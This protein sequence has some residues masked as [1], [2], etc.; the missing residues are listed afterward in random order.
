M[1]KWIKWILYFFSGIIILLFLFILILQTNWAKGFVR[2]KLQTY[3]SQ[4][5]KTEF[6]IGS[7]DYSLPKWI[8]LNGVFMRDMAKDTILF[9]S[10]I[11][12]DIAMFK[13]VSGKFEINKIVLD[14]VYI[15]LTKKEQ[16]SIFN[17]QFI[18][19]AFKSKSTDAKEIK[20]NS[21]LNL[22]IKDIELKHLRFNKSDYNE[23][24]LMQISVGAFHL[25][26][27][28][29]DLDKM[30]FDINKLY[31]DSVKFSFRILKEQVD[32]SVATQIPFPILKAD[33]LIIKNSSIF[34][35]NKSQQIYTNNRIGLLQAAKLNNSKDANTF[36]GKY[37]ALSNSD[38][39]FNHSLKNESIKVNDRA[40]KITSSK[41]SSVN[42]ILDEMSLLQN[43][44]TYNNIA[45]PEKKLGLDYFHLGIS[46]L[47]LTANATKYIDGNIQ[48]TIHRFSFKDK[49]GFSLDSLSG[50]VIVDSN[51]ISLKNFVLRTPNSSINAKAVVY[52]A[53]FKIPIKGNGKLQDNDITLSKTIIGKKDIELLIDGLTEQYKKQLD[54]LGNLVVDA[55]IKGNSSKLYIKQLVVNAT[56]PNTLNLQMTGVI[57]NASDAK[58]IRY[59]TNIKNLSVSQKIISPFLKDVKQKISLPPIININGSVAGDLKNVQANLTTN[60]ANGFA[61]IK[62]NLIQFT[63]P[64][65]MTYDIGINATNLETGKWI[66]QD[67]VLGKLNGVI[68]IKGSGGFNVKN[69]NMK[70]QAAVKSFRYKANTINNVNVNS[71]FNK[72]IINGTASVKDQLLTMNANG[73]ANIHNE[74]P[75]ID[76]IANIAN[77][78]LLALGL[79]KDTLNITALTKVKIEDASPKNLK[80]IIRI[81][82]VI[83][84]KNGQKIS[85]D[86][87]TV[88]AF[89]K[90]DSTIIQVLSP[91]A[92]ANLKSTVYYNQIPIL[93]QQ[94]MNQYLPPTSALSATKENSDIPS[95]T[96]QA[97][98]IL[99][100]NEAYQAFTKNITF[101][102]AIT[103]NANI[104]N[105]SKDSSIRVILNAPGL[106]VNNIRLGNM[107]GTALGN[108]DSLNMHIVIDTVKA[109][110]VLLYDAII[111][112]GF[113]KN[114]LHTS[115]TTK[116]ENKKEQFKLAVTAKPNSI[117]GYDLSLGKDLMLN[118]QNWIVNQQNII[119]TSK[120]GFNVQNFDIS[121]NGQKIAVHNETALAT[122]PLIVDINNF[123]LSSISAA[124]NKDSIA[125][126]GLLNVH[127]KLSDLKNAI[128]TMDGTV[129]LDSIMYQNMSVGNLDLKAQSANSNVSVSGKLLGNGNNVDISGSY[130]A[131]NI[132]VKINLNPITLASIQP[133]TK[134]NLSRSSGFVS[135]PINITGSINNPQWNGELT[136]NKVQTTAAQFGTVLKIDNQKIIFNYPTIQLNNFTLTDST[137]NAI[138]INGTV[139]QN[140]DKNFITDL[141]VN[142]NGFHALNNSAVDNNI[143]YGNAIVD[144]DANIKGNITAPDITGNLAIKN[145]TQ[146]IFVRQNIPASAKDREG[147][148]EFVD[149]DTVTNLLT[150]KTYQEVIELQQK[151]TSFGAF[152]YNLNIDVE[153]E[154]KFNIIIDPITRDELQVQGQAQINAGVNPNGSVALSGVYNLKKGSYQLNY[155]FIKRK[156]SL[157][158]GSTITLSGDP[159]K[160]SADITAI[161][162]IKTSAYDLVG[163]EM[164][165]TTDVENAI[166][167]KKIPFQVLLKIKG[168]IMAPELSFDIVVKEKAEGVS[169]EMAT[170]IDNKLQQLRAD[171]SAMNKQVFALLVLNRFIGEQSRDFF[172]GNGSNNRSVLANESVSGF[173]NGAINQIAADLI[174]GIDIDINLKN[175]DDDPNAQRTDLSVALSKSFLDD[176]LSVSVGKSF[177]VEGSDPSA[178]GR[179]TTNSNVQFIPDVNTTYK[180]SKDGKYML[181]AYR[182]NQYEALLDGYFIE[183]GFTFSFT[184]NYNKLIELLNRKKK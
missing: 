150:K 129:Q 1:R 56:R 162:E 9:G 29:L 31:A 121:N 93:V 166:Y 133:F 153:P 143:L 30:H 66:G 10:K 55:H 20:S 14:D 126:E 49:S 75:T 110:N 178:N 112:S 48:S 167:K 84:Q 116:D 94:V 118:H 130:N 4:K 141:S 91:F 38:I 108:G 148:M 44:I 95:G 142:A 11:K 51:F 72:G 71:T 179:N 99:K 53:S 85:I 128:P 104:S 79:S 180:L 131:Q 28:S 74:Y 32:T 105:K 21:P 13:L 123:K 164:N 97:N 37:F 42:F 119:R 64:E 159:K 81:D 132:D 174:K 87:A 173:L 107:Q 149:M 160:A 146:V 78:D 80:A 135:G 163:G 50:E 19:D 139:T 103:I 22:S 17:Y 61:V 138:K 83:I 41:G 137:N 120:D 70:L 100:P 6:A 46:G 157:L 34:F 161:Y 52:P 136:F 101:N 168:E 86:S 175:V 47:N 69:N 102:E 176:R 114:S 140:Q 27:D 117:E 181:R 40:V 33:S 144:V 68:A 58:N 25:N 82:S 39:E 125:V 183:T 154:A 7:I 18:V 184:V 36:T 182:K 67:S 92:I 65:N 89:V 73:N 96:I 155:Q 158:D 106:Q 43:N 151:E 171:P 165:T 77:A 134:N 145:G 15:N 109:G 122:A 169:Y 16:D 113:S 63:K 57:E 35:E 88:F 26:V 76:A 60:S 3:I 8:E 124:L 172:A 62:A 59:N 156:F 115:L 2:D 24:T 98:I 111:I 90:N 23:G 152:T 170:T 177:T 147:V 54:E 12:V 127:A 5:T 45:M